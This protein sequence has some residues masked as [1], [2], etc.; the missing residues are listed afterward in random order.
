MF[1]ERSCL[2][3]SVFLKRGHSTNLRSSQ[4]SKQRCSKVSSIGHNKKKLPP[5]CW[6]DDFLGTLSILNFMRRQSSNSIGLTWDFNLIKKKNRKY[7][8]SMKSRQIFFDN[9][10]QLWSRPYYWTNFEK[11]VFFWK[12]TFMQLIVV[13]SF[14][15]CFDAAY[16]TCMTQSLV[17]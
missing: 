15:F 1:E 11:Q 3:S 4:K 7:I 9:Q 16:C 2:S 6:E 5:F 13:S 14:Y 17:F 12:L 10:C 8:P